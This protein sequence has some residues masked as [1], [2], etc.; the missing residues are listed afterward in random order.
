MRGVPRP[1]SAVILRLFLAAVVCVSLTLPAASIDASPAEPDG[2]YL[3]VATRRSGTLETELNAAGA[4][5]YR[6]VSAWWG[7]TQ[8]EFVVLLQRDDA[9][10][11]REFRVLE[12]VEP[13][14][15]DAAAAEGF[16][17]VPGGLFRN[18]GTL[19]LERTA[20]DTQRR[21]YRVV[22]TLATYDWDGRNALY[23]R[24][25]AGA[26][27]ELERLP[28]DG[29]RLVGM[30]ALHM[31]RGQVHHVFIEEKLPA[32][33]TPADDGLGGAGP[34]RLISGRPGAD[35]Q[36]QLNQAAAD[37]YRLRFGW[38]IKL[39]VPEHLSLV[40]ERGDTGAGNYDYLLLE[41]GACCLDNQVQGA[42][43]RGYRPHPQGFFG[44]PEVVIMERGPG[45]R[46][47]H[48][49]R[50]LGTA[51]TGNFH[52]DVTA[53][54]VQGY[55]L[56]VASDWEQPVYHGEGRWGRNSSMHFGLVEKEIDPADAGWDMGAPAVAAPHLTLGFEAAEKA[57]NIE[58]QLNE[59]AG[60]GYCL[61]N[62]AAYHDGRNFAEE[63]G[64]TLERRTGSAG[65]EYRVLATKRVSS[66]EKDLNE[67]AAEGFRLVPGTLFAKPAFMGTRENAAVMERTPQSVAEP[68]EYRLLATQRFSTL[69]E[70]I[71][72]AEA[73]GYR[74]VARANVV[75]NV[76][77]MERPAGLTAMRT[78]DEHD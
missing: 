16:R 71:A 54:A 59:V 69:L 73:E 19:I 65:C 35:L 51:G 72:E 38:A 36:E 18:R 52:S 75:E 31:G 62:V 63:L 15:L 41:T 53:M 23:R 74:M 9:G 6:L 78:P 20:G 57:E 43:L 70:E 2:R 39:R 5:S 42:G 61:V 44:V 48:E 21:E 49:Y 67:A 27:A 46:T 3:L 25:L 47:A 30:M 45:E 22:D 11:S 17:V 68:V 8:D 13:A 26:E 64:L 33:A 40:M 32:A 60:G 66:M 34:Y 29:Y 77:Y 1:L 37:G 4:A 50:W 28:Q 55:E 58:E 56:V 12:E 24:D 7:G 76:A 10:T 14:A